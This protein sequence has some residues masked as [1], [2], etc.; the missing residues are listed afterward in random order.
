MNF[1]FSFFLY[2][3]KRL[4]SV[5]SGENVMHCMYCDLAVKSCNMLVLPGQPAILVRKQDVAI[6]NK[7]KVEKCIY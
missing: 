5:K 2:V 1:K 3:K 4:E 6:T 7:R